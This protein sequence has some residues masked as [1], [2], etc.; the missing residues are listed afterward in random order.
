MTLVVLDSKYLNT[1]TM[2]KLKYWLLCIVCTICCVQHSDAQ[3]IT[4]FTT[5]GDSKTIA[6]VDSIQLYD[7]NQLNLTML[8]AD[9]SS[10]KFVVSVPQNEHWVYA[11]IACENYDPYQTADILHKGVHQVGT[12]IIEIR[13]GD[14]APKSAEWW[15]G[16]YSIKPGTAYC[17]LVAKAQK[18]YHW[19]D[20][21][22]AI[23]WGPIASNGD[24]GDS[25]PY[26]P[27]DELNFIPDYTDDVRL[28]N[29]LTESLGDETFEGFFYQQYFWTAAPTVAAESP[30]VTVNY[31][32][33]TKI[34]YS[35]SLPSNVY[36]CKSLLLTDWEY[37]ENGLGMRLV[38]ISDK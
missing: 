13:D 34:H 11:L 17:V 23:A 5:D 16:T 29:Y 21:H 32:N 33:H 12:Q 38:K 2:M 28:G 14:A 27:E 24:S 8:K 7:S 18:N 26:S 36:D 10:V 9:H 4:V 20:G 35:I 37:A 25:Y 22:G 15:G 30:V 19:D 6:N 3:T 31:K 1:K